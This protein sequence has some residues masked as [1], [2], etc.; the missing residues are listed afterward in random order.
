DDDNAAGGRLEAHGQINS[1]SNV[2]PRGLT[3]NPRPETA[4]QDELFADTVE[5]HR[6]AWPQFSTVRLYKIQ[7]VSADG[8]HEV[9][10]GVLVFLLE[11]RDEFSLILSRHQPRLECLRIELDA[12]RH[13]RYQRITHGLI[14]SEIRG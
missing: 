6:G 13:S 14:L 10:F 4:I 11:K 8:Q 9:N 12:A 7:A 5:H 1:A 3:R 2:E